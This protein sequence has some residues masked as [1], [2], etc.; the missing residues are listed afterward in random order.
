MLFM[1]P[2]A[3][4]AQQ[5]VVDDSVRWTLAAGD[6]SPRGAKPIG[7]PAAVIQNLVFSQL[8]AALRAYDRSRGGWQRMDAWLPEGGAVMPL[9]MELRG[10]SGTVDIG[11][12][13]LRVLLDST[14][15]ATRFEVP[16]QG[17]VV[18]WHDDLAFPPRG[19][20]CRSR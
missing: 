15:W 16:A 2:G 14:G 20:R 18:T 11:G 1:A 13:S 10:D 4:E 3:L 17:V 19:V 9:G 5:V 6:R 7:R 8:A 12:V